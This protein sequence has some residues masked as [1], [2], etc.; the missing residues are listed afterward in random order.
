[1]TSGIYLKFG[2]GVLWDPAESRRSFATANI[3]RT[4]SSWIHPSW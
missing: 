3:H 4:V 2:P 1:M